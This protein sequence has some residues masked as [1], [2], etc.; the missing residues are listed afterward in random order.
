MSKTLSVTL[1]SLI[2]IL[3]IHLLMKH[4]TNKNRESNEKQAKEEE[5]IQKIMNV[6]LPNESTTTTQQYL[7]PPTVSSTI[8]LL[9]KD[10]LDKKKLKKNDT[11]IA[12]GF[13]VGLSWGAV[14]IKW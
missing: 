6:Q 3:L 4:F 10:C 14:Q 8:P 5:A 7:Q 13:G 11:I 9:L 12:C 1:K 2:F